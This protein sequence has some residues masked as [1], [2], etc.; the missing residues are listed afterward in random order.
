MKT[1]NFTISLKKLHFI[2]GIVVLAAF[3]WSCDNTGAIE[4]EVNAIPVNIE[5]D[6]FDI[7]FYEGSTKDIPALNACL[8]PKVFILSQKITVSFCPQYLK[9]VSMTSETFLFVNNLFTKLNLIL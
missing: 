5:T 3:F 7:K 8:K 1:K 2:C 4:N 9:I 6:R